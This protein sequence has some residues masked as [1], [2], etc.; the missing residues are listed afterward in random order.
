MRPGSRPP[1]GRVKFAQVRR[2]LPVTRRG[3]Q[4][5]QKRARAAAMRCNKALK[6]CCFL[7]REHFKPYFSVFRFPAC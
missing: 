2:F 7:S 3:G 1:A 5:W 4:F 6:Q